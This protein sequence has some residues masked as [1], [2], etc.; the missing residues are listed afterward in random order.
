M[1][2]LVLQEAL[3]L[4]NPPQSKYDV[5][6]AAKR[7][8]LAKLAGSKT[9]AILP[10]NPQP[11]VALDI[12]ES[13]FKDVESTFQPVE[14]PTIDPKDYFGGDYVPPESDEDLVEANDTAS[15]NPTKCISQSGGNGLG[16]DINPVR[17]HAK[18]F[19]NGFAGKLVVSSRKQSASYGINPQTLSKRTLFNWFPRRSPPFGNLEVSVEWNNDKGAG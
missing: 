16:A 1:S 15:L 6:L 9:E 2:P 11:S 8:K 7:L 4:K 12:T 13:I 18:A 3:K 10:E 19:C 5:D 17:E 14:V